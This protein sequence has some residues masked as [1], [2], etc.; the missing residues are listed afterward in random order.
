M[1]LLQ[2]LIEQA[3]NPKGFVGSTMLCIMNTAHSGMTKWVIQSGAIQ[4][5]DIVLD[6][7]CGGGKTIQT[8]SKINKQGKI[9]G[10]DFSEQA[11]KDSIKA[12]KEDVSS[13]KVIV[14]QASVSSIPY[15]DELFDKITAFQT[16]YFWPNLATG[17]K[18]VFRVLKK[19]GQFMIISEIYKINYHMKSYKT[20]TEIRQLFESTGFQTVE[21][22]EDTKKGWLYITGIR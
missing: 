6:I 2:S 10:I 5:G 16:H 11:V 7:G 20:K 3:K 12:N 4:N 1:S 21:I 19:G 18:E 22:L 13:G 17:V 15:P 14:R 8:L 9:Y